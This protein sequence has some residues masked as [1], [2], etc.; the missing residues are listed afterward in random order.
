MR[1]DPYTRYKH[2]RVENPSGPNSSFPAYL[3][4]VCGMANIHRWRLRTG[5]HS[6]RRA[7]G[8]LVHSTARTSRSLPCK[9]GA[10]FEITTAATRPLSICRR[11]C[12]HSTHAHLRVMTLTHL[13]MTLTPGHAVACSRMPTAIS[14][15]Y[16]D[17]TH[18]VS[19]THGHSLTHAI[20]L[21]HVVPLTHG[22]SSTH[23]V[24]GSTHFD[25]NATTHTILLTHAVSFTQRLSPT[26]CARCSTHFVALVITHTG[27]STPGNRATTRVPGASIPPSSSCTRP[28]HSPPN[29][30]FQPPPPKKIFF[31]AF[32]HVLSDFQPP[33]MISNPPA[34]PP[35]F[36]FLH[37]YMF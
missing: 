34:P 14:L 4:S 24:L 23:G 13:D 17:L 22:A 30:F 5:F 18:A 10:V 31:F 7:R 15:T 6:R 1:D 29:F 2:A 26:P 21:A 25:T 9:P 27:T 3:L 32:L 28:Q 37:F 33:Q 12:C 35:I 20:S 16:S 36:F 11:L 8:G 19:L